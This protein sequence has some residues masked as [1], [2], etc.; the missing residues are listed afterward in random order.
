MSVNLSAE[1][2]N[3]AIV[4]HASSGKTVLSEAMLACSGTIGRMGRITDGSTVSDYHVSEKQP[5]ISTQTSLLHT[6]WMDKKFNI[7]DTPGYLDFTSEALAALRVADLALIVVHAQHGIGVGTERVW[8][9]ATECGIPKILAINAMD[10]E[11]ANFASVLADARAHYG[12]RVFPMNV[13]I[14]PGPGFN[15]VLDVLRSDI[16]SY[17]AS[18]RGRFTE[19]PAAGDWKAQAARLHGEL[20]EFIAESDDTLLTQFFDQGGLTE[21]EFRSGIHS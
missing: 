12:P 15:Q 19:E 3:F 13:P 16:A 21:E 1:I 2:R 14:N 20:I 11:N 9:Y 7:M 4:G 8:D 10:K 6:T 18:A 17:D 5:Q